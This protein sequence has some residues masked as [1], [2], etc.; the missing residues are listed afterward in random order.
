MPGPA[1]VTPGPR[2][3]MGAALGLPA[4][5]SAGLGPRS[6]PGL[7]CAGTGRGPRCRGRR[8]GFCASRFSQG[9]VAAA[10]AE[11]GCCLRSQRT[12]SLVTALLS[13]GL[14]EV[15]PRSVHLSR[16]N[17]GGGGV[18]KPPP[19]PA[20]PANPS[21]GAFRAALAPHWQFS[22][23][24]MTSP[25]GPR[26]LRRREGW[27][28]GL[29]SGDLALIYRFLRRLAGG[30]CLGRCSRTQRGSAGAGKRRSPFHR[31]Q[32]A[33]QGNGKIWRGGGHAWG[34]TGPPRGHLGM[35][36]RRGCGARQAPPCFAA[37]GCSSS[38]FYSSSPRSGCTSRVSQ[39]AAAPP[40]SL[41]HS[42]LAPG[43]PPAPGRW[44]GAIRRASFDSPSQ[45]PL[46][47][48]IIG[49]VNL[50]DSRS[51]QP[52]PFPRSPR[53]RRARLRVPAS[54]RGRPATP[55]KGEGPGVFFFCA[56][57][58]GQL[59]ASVWFFPSPPS[60]LFYFYS[61]SSLSFPSSPASLG[62]ADAHK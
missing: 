10:S 3:R 34:E 20:S 45:L 55:H 27:G 26:G 44:R 15:P 46:F 43:R 14:P 40:R 51:L 52:P 39:L 47:N 60:S 58:E 32:R 36:E 8:G 59:P 62:S 7:A 5:R 61:F 41:P 4:G 22:P 53:P 56:R 31:L 54:P 1:L 21:A 33:E 37:L 9:F 49:K 13:F 29:G 57:G 35:A 28:R 50:L 17:R 11:A 48:Q 23:E 25:G 12:R 2:G 38:L 30:R 16:K 42:C 24:E 18:E 6:P 19:P